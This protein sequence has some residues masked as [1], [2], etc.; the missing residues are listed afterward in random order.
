M[1]FH[2]PQCAQALNLESLR[3]QGSQ[4]IPPRVLGPAEGSA[5]ANLAVWDRQALLRVLP[6]GA[7]CS[8]QGT[9]R[10]THMSSHSRGRWPRLGCRPGPLCVVPRTFSEAGGEPQSLHLSRQHPGHLDQSHTHGREVRRQPALLGRVARIR[11]EL[12]T[13]LQ[14][15]TSPWPPRNLSMTTALL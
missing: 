13:G 7:L 14:A 2:S 15:G 1:A 3:V 4:R 8:L 5:A 9:E 10:T 6:S 12:G 11:R